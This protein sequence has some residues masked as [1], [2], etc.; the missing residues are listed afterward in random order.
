MTI[1]NENYPRAT[2]CGAKA[3]APSLASLETLKIGVMRFRAEGGI[4]SYIL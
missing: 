1:S 2:S 4:L 3:C